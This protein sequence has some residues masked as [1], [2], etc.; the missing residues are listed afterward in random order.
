MDNSVDLHELLK[1]WPYDPDDNVRRVRCKDGREV[2]Q[3]RLPLGIEQ[4]ELNGRPDGE[5]PYGKESILEYHLERL[6]EAKREGTEDEFALNSD[7]CEEL[8][9]EGTLYYYRY[10]HLFQAKEWERTVRD[11]S[12][13]LQVF[14]LVHEYAEDEEDQLYLEQWRPYLLRMNASARAMLLLE[15]GNYSQALEAVTS[16]ISAIEKLEDLEEETFEFER[17]RALLALKEIAAQ[18]EQ[19]KPVS[20]LEMLERELRKAIETQHFERAA[21]LRDRIRAL[22]KDPKP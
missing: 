13:N 19:S 16:A 11:T 15:Q 12:R 3:V 7:H 8:F 1:S 6:A 4:Y 17:E 22:R 2:L 9:A 14:D 10:L 21:N 18:I 5:R 20:E